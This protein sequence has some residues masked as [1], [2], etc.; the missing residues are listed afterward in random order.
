MHASN[1]SARLLWERQRE[2]GIRYRENY[3]TAYIN[4][5][6]LSKSKN[7]LWLINAL[8]RHHP[9]LFASADMEAT[10]LGRVSEAL[11]PIFLN[12]HAMILHG[13][14]DAHSYGELVAWEDHSDAFE[15]M[16]TMRQFIPGE[17]LP[18]LEIQERVLD[19]L[20][21]CCRAIIHDIPAYSLTSSTFPPQPSLM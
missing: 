16:H 3:M 21:Q 18:V 12:E 1:A 17:G 6:D 10:S 14:T 11:V 7:L 13:A 5:E 20:V 19:V 4:Q 15:W 8:G 2:A 9:S